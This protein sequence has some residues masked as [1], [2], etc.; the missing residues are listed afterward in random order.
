M[1]AKSKPARFTI[2]IP[3]D[4]NAKKLLRDKLNK[5]K[6]MM[7]HKISQQVNNFEA[8]DSLIDFWFEQNNL[9]QNHGF[10]SY[11]EVSDDKERNY[12]LQQTPP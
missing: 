7:T 3:G 8:L 12:L 5:Y 2:E 6:D 1:A 10:V 11:H 9:Q 4:E